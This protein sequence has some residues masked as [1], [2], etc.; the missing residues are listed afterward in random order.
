MKVDIPN[1]SCLRT[2][3]QPVPLRLGN[4]Q[5]RWGLSVL[6]VQNCT[7]T[8]IHYDLDTL[9]PGEPVPNVFGYS[10]YTDSTCTSSVLP[11]QKLRRRGAEGYSKLHRLLTSSPLTFQRQGK[12]QIDAEAVQIPCQ[13]HV[14]LGDS[15]LIERLK[16]LA[17]SKVD[18]VINL[19]NEVRFTHPD[20][21]QTQRFVK[22]RTSNIKEEDFSGFQS[23]P[24]P[25]TINTGLC[26]FSG[27][28]TGAPAPGQE[29]D[30]PM[31][32]APP[33]P[34]STRASM[35]EMEA[36]A[37]MAT[38]IIDI[39]A[40]VHMGPA[41]TQ[42]IHV[43]LDIPAL[44]YYCQPLELFQKGLVDRHYVLEWLWIVDRRHD[45]IEAVLRDAVFYGCKLRGSPVEFRLL[46]GT[47]AATDLVK[48]C[49]S[50]ENRIPVIKEVMDALETTGPDKALWCLFLD[51][52]DEKEKPKN[53]RGL[54]RIGYVFELLRPFLAQVVTE[55]EIGEQGHPR[56]LM[57]QVDDIEEWKIFDRAN[58]LLK[59]FKK[60]RGHQ[61]EVSPLLVGVFPS[62]RIF[63]QESGGRTSLY[64]HDPGD[65]IL[66]A[67][68]ESTPMG[69][70]STQPFDIISRIYGSEFGQMIGDLFTKHGMS[71]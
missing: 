28:L 6:N 31:S 24:P 22:C 12:R 52:L 25:I 9:I 39:A 63:T 5:T 60:T 42:P 32:S 4:P 44:Q 57:I 43:L 70:Q 45:Q 20:G 23:N 46:S 56:P 59:K 53:I 71:I 30:V 13:R 7:S 10:F 69:S 18:D 62:H 34:Y 19:F 49:V 67:A 54:S 8:V 66:Q 47:Q 26:I 27:R 33:L 61:S 15:L 41:K 35:Y 68:T 3:E 51:L 65:C 21:L 17:K 64:W 40:T 14:E 58:R 50:T 55:T 36:I 48:R 1:G 11:L 29:N 16:P 37:Q 38:T 2:E